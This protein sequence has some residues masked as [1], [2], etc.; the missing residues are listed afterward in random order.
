[1]VDGQA[2]TEYKS[3]VDG[4]WDCVHL[5]S[6]CAVLVEKSLNPVSI[7]MMDGLQVLHLQEETHNERESP[8]NTSAST[9][10]FA[11]IRTRFILIDLFFLCALIAVVTHFTC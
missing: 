2:E 3:T 7:V 4:N 1:M 5:L 8:E 6:V 9:L 10:S 11:K